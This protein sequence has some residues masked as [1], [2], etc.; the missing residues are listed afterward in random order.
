MTIDVA[1]R[2]LAEIVKKAEGF[3]GEITFDTAKPD[4]T[5]RRP[6]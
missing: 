1:I 6:R 2:E 4:G 3:T 5:P